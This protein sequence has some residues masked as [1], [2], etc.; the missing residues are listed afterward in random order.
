MRRCSVLAMP[1]LIS[2]TFR[3]L[4]TVPSVP[5]SPSAGVGRRCYRFSLTGALDWPGDGSGSLA[6]DRCHDYFYSNRV[7]IL[8]PVP[9][10]QR[11]EPKERRKADEVPAAD[12]AALSSHSAAAALDGCAARMS[13]FR[14]RTTLERQVSEMRRAGTERNTRHIDGLLT[15]QSEQRRDHTTRQRSERTEKRTAARVRAERE[16][17]WLAEESEARGLNRRLERQTRGEARRLKRRLAAHAAAA[18]DDSSGDKWL[19]RRDEDRLSRLEAAADALLVSR[20]VH[21]RT[22]RLTAAVG[23][24]TAGARR[25]R[26]LFDR[27]R[28]VDSW[29][30]EVEQQRPYERQQERQ[31]QRWAMQRTRERQRRE[32]DNDH[33]QQS[34]RSRHRRA[35]AAEE[36]QGGRRGAV[37]TTKLHTTDTAAAALHPRLVSS[38]QRQQHHRGR[39]QVR[40]DEVRTGGAAEQPHREEH[41]TTQPAKRSASDKERL[42]RRLVR[43]TMENSTVAGAQADETQTEQSQPRQPISARQSQLREQQHCLPPTALGETMAVKASVVCSGSRGEKRAVATNDQLGPDR[44]SLQSVQSQQH[45]LGAVISSCPPAACGRDPPLFASPQETNLAPLSPFAQSRCSPSSPVLPAIGRGRA[46][47]TLLVH[48]G[49]SVAA[50]QMQSQLRSTAIRPPSAF[51]AAIGLS[52]WQQ[53]HIT[54]RHHTQPRSSDYMAGG[55]STTDPL[56]S[57]RLRERRQQ[58]TEERTQQRTASDSHTAGQ[59]IRRI[60]TQHAQDGAETGTESTDERPSQLP[61]LPHAYRRRQG[62]GS[63]RR[64]SVLV[65][66]WKALE[67]EAELRQWRA[68]HESTH[69]SNS[70]HGKWAKA[71]G[72]WQQSEQRPVAST[73]AAAAAAA[74]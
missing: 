28:L 19:R 50:E 35:A 56:H 73:A 70:L 48:C 31:A 44:P 74:R 3:A 14:Q 6:L 7:R 45:E 13:A 18:C 22:V 58:T 34:T 61:P 20:A 63:R 8:D 26:P 65:E 25:L 47:T 53:P 46:S 36:C 57:A 54:R 49:S 33:S 68:E 51:A 71:I 27:R 59:L 21:A 43:S 29:A 5:S 17:G 11:S 1:N 10:D 38:Q 4:S 30:R 69:N 32:E 52:L 2:R 67:E 23:T 9:A 62:S 64:S 39:R 12:S 24:E 72:K 40:R 42:V 55:G 66:Q 37:F 15:R 41:F 60:V 16:D